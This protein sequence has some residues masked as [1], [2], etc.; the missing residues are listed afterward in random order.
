MK[1]IVLLIGC[2]LYINSLR[3][4]DP[5]FAQYY[6]APL[7]LNPAFSGTANDHRFISNYRNQWPNVSNG[8]VTYAFSYD[9]NMEQLNSGLG[10]LVV[11]DRA[12][13]ANLKSTTCNFQYAYKVHLKDKWMLSS[14]LNFGF[15]SRSVDFSKLV[16]GDQLAFDSKGN[17]TTDDAVFSNL[18]S[19]NYFDLGAG[20]LTYTRK[21][22]LGFSAAHL[23]RPNR[24]LLGEQAEIPVKTSFHGGVRIPLYHGVFKKDRIAAIAPSFVYKHQ[25]RFD[26]LDVGTYFFYEPIVI[27]LWYRGIPIMQT[28][29]DNV[30][31]DAI[32]VIL[33]FQLTKVDLTYS[34]DLTVSKLGPIS[35]GAHEI[36]LKYKLNL[37]MQTTKRKKERFIPCPTF[38]KD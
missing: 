14:G 35:G 28:T 25:G 18:Q 37:G 24:S 32:I 9:Y 4:Q 15:G 3:A 13:S 38:N 10:F 6:A 16:F 29:K 2:V 26:Q 27:G 8:F 36:A 5:E 7:Y 17:S 22:W 12:G 23:N 19:T 21:F 20:I 1:K 33:G 11:S 34:Y 30:N 31:Q